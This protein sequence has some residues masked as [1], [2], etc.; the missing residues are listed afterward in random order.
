MNIDPT[1][2]PTE[3]VDDDGSLHTDRTEIMRILDEVITQAHY[4]SIG[5]GRLRDMEKE[6]KRLEYMEM[7]VRAVEQREKFIPTED[8]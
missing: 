2:R 8:S 7:I 6:K 5:D 4:K 1:K 3:Y